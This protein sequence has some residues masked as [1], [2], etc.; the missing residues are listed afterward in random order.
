MR[1]RHAVTA[2]GIA[3]VT[4]FTS[5][6]MSMTADITL[7]DQAKGTGSMVISVNKQLASMAGIGTSEAFKSLMA[8]SGTNTPAN[9]TIETSES[10]TDYVATVSFSDAVLDD[11]DFGAR[12]LE[13]GNINFTFVNEGTQTS[14]EDELLGDMDL[15][16]ATLTVNFPGEVIEFSGEG[17]TKV[18]EDTVQWSFPLTKGTTATATSL[19][20][21]STFP[22]LPVG[23]GLL[24]LAVVA[25]A[26]F[27]VMRH[28]A[29][30]SPT[31]ALGTGLADDSAEGV[32]EP[33]TAE[34]NATEANAT[35]P[36]A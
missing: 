36:I 13:N 33:D 24:A 25:G 32:A 27:F 17:A 5:G 1:I 21:G 20:A 11:K 7:D 31:A 8:Q 26:V 30:Q 12:V 15:G 2:V 6:C 4:L 28:R 34:A 19:V 14:S 22:F 3:A 9:A 23:L 16:N 10:D 29:A 35:E 18:D